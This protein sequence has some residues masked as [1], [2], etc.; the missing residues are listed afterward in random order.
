VTP[1]LL[2]TALYHGDPYPTFRH[3]RA[4][5]PVF[6]QAEPGFYAI[7]RHADVLRVLKDHLAYSS[8]DGTDIDV[9]PT[10]AVRSIL[11]TDP[12]RHTAIRKLLSAEFTPRKLLDI[13]LVVRRAVTRLLDALPVGQPFDFA[14]TVADA[15]P[16]YVVGRLIGIAEA[17]DERFKVWNQRM[18][19]VPPFGPEAQ[20]IRGEMTDYFSWLR[21]QRRDDPR[22]DIVSRLARAQVDGEPLG[23]NEFFGNLLTLMTAGQDTTSNLISGGVCELASQP[24]SWRALQRDPDL[25]AG[26]VEEMARHVLSVTFLARRTLTDTLIGDVDVAKDT[27]VALFFMSANRDERVFDAPDRFDIRRTPNPHLAFGFGRHFCIGAA[28]ARMEA[29]V[30]FAALTSRYARIE[31]LGVGRM[32]SHIFPGIQHLPAVLHEQ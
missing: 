28:L 14:T 16:M 30:M 25:I 1:D 3:L 29:R 19:V 27:K 5:Q 15:L 21:T 6:W 12:P 4:S 8:A 24:E 32:K 2:D 7:T 23:D 11:H 31:V 26:A 9:M 22:D 10:D 13:E 17:D 20:T 18:I